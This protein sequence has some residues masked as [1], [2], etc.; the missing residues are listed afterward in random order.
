M[1][2]GT[3][4]IV[5][6]LVGLFFV[7]LRFVD[8]RVTKEIAEKLGKT[9]RVTR[10]LLSRAFSQLR[11]IMLGRSPLGRPIRQ[12]GIPRIKSNVARPR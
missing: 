2:R 8:G 10:V 4:D 11:V 3:Q 5:S 7:R 6:D 1:V 12:R 9:D